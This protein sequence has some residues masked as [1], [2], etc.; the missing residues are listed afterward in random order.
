MSRLTLFVIID[1]TK[2]EQPA[3]VRAADLA[4]IAGGHIHAFCS[5]YEDDLSAYNSRRDAKYKVRQG[6]RDKVDDLTNPLVNDLATVSKE[7]IW[8]ERWYQAAVHACAR[9]GAD[10]M[11]KSTY[12]HEKSLNVLRK[13]SDYHLLR[14]NSCPVLLTQSV[15][16]CRYQRVLAAIALEDGDHRHDDLNNL[17]ISHARRLC[18][19]TE[20]ELHVVAALK[21]RLN[22]AN[23]HGFKMIEDNK[24]LSNEQLINARFGIESESIHLANGPAKRVIA[25]V[26]EQTA[27]QLIVIGT[28]A[29]TG[30]SG[31]VLGNT[32]EKILDQLPID[33]LTVN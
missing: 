12:T 5:V 21:D 33:I 7:I 4:N 11:I 19:I 32:C 17:I 20:G 6:A 3:L 24:E 15:K 23:L 13:R 9:A 28:I 26:A 14:H 22:I 27:A 18:R 10:I 30:I 1:P 2:E 29:R 25:E 31:A 16:H 8:N